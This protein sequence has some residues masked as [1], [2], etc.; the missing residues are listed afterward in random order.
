MIDEVQWGRTTIRYGYE[1]RDRKTLA[2]HVHPDLSVSVSAPDGTHLATIRAKVRKRARWIYKARREFQLYLPKQPERSYVNGETH[3]YLGKQYRLK[4]VHGDETSVKCQR[5]YLW[6]TT[7]HRPSPETSRDLLDEWYTERALAIFNERLL[8][9][10]KKVARERIPYPVLAI[11]K[12]T[13]RWGSCTKEGRITLNLEMIKAPKDCIDYVIIHELCHLKEHNHGQ[14]F[15][16]L[17]ARVM[18]DYEERRR[19]LNMVVDM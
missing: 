5:G 8:A 6:V 2:I 15:W 12:M 14:K 10:H 11:R 4:A 13:R 18:P 19:R 9:C 3:R 7:P 16:K 1:Y 17:L